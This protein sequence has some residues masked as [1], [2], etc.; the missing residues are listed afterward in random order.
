MQIADY[1][2]KFE[3]RPEFMDKTIRAEEAAYEGF[4]QLAKE[5]QLSNAEL[6]AAM[7]QYFRVTKAD[8]R[9]PTG[10]D[11][12]SSLAKITAK[13]ADLDKRTIGFIREQ[14]KTY[15]KPIL[16][17]V[18]AHQVL[19]TPAASAPAGLS[20]GQEQELTKWFVRVLSR[21]MQPTQLTPKFVAE[22]PQAGASKGQDDPAL[23]P[24]KQAIIGIIR[25]AFRPELM[26]PAMHPTPAATTT[27]APGTAPTSASG[28]A[29]PPN[30]PA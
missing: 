9:Q 30:Q 23:A 14:E 29:L 3:F 2:Q 27:A 21:G 26:V 1:Q 16:T 18:L 13:L 28:T 15:L 7:V 22:A 8:P 4:R 17:Q 25:L 11:L 6:L 10:P 19:S 20:A 12:T 5:C 24:I